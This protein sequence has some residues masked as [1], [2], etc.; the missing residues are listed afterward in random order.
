MDEVTENY[1]CKIA[2]T[3]EQMIE[4]I[5]HGFTFVHEKDGVAYFKKR[6]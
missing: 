5:E 3:K 1:T 2:E 4:L 6:K